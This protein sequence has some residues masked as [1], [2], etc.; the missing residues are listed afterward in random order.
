MRT[1][2][3]HP[4]GRARRFCSHIVQDELAQ[5]AQS[6]QVQHWDGVGNPSSTLQAEG[7]QALQPRQRLCNMREVL[8]G[9]RQDQVLELRQRRHKGQTG[10]RAQQH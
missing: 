6:L 8:A 7:L 2:M 4:V 3:R 1:D 10:G 5:V 9:L